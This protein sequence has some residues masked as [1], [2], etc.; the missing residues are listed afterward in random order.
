MFQVG[1]RVT[2]RCEEEPTINGMLG[3]VERSPRTLNEDIRL[4]R[5]DAGGVIMAYTK[6][7]QMTDIL[8]I[9]GPYEID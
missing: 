8:P 4:I 2:I 3:H 9:D 6:H 7:L 5:L 1:D